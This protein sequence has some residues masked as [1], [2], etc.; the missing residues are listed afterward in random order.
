MPGHTIKPMAQRKVLYCKTLSDAT[1]PQRK[2][3]E[4]AGYDLCAGETFSIRPGETVFVRTGLV[5]QPDPGL[6]TEIVVRSGIAAKHNIFLANNVGVI[7]RDFAGPEDEVKVM[8]YRGPKI[9][10]SGEEPK[11]LKEDPVRF[12]KG[13]RI[14]QLL[15]R[16]TVMVK[17][18]EIEQAPAH[19]D[20]G[21]FGSTGMD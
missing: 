10:W 7:D 11:I 8:L 13:D 14:A 20:R 15:F 16:E 18:E 21:G 19:E 4:A 9:D 1:P 3:I 6:H 17:M 5:M 12:K 2:S